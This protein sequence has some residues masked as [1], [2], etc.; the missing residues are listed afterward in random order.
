M[1]DTKCLVATVTELL[2]VILDV[3]Q[4]TINTTDTLALHLRVG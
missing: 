2:S 3:E 4:N 1:Y